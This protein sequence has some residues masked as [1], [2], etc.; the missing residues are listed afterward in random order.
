MTLDDFIS[1]AF[2]HYLVHVSRQRTLYTFFVSFA[3]S[4][5]FR[6]TTRFTQHPHSHIIY[7][8]YCVATYEGININDK[9]VAYAFLVYN[10]PSI[11]C[12]LMDLSLSACPRLA[13]HLRQDIWFLL[14][15]GL[16]VAKLHT[17]INY[18]KAVKRSVLWFE[19]ERPLIF[20][21]TRVRRY[22]LYLTFE[23]QKW[24]KSRIALCPTSVS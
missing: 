11:T 20:N 10:K 14:N 8:I 22:Y 3:L 6:H 7:P 2:V 9:F 21:E 12:L 16:F 18:L 1:S 4:V 24:N 13:M 19:T 17:F 23:E 5:S 15:F